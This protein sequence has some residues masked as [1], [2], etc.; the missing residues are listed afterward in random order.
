MIETQAEAAVM[1]RT[2]A[3]FEQVND[4]LQGTLRTL[5]SELSVLS[6]SWRGQGAMAFERVKAD[7]AADLR[8]LGMALTET[9]EA[10]RAA[11]AG[12]QAADAGAAARLTRAGQ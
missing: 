10:I 2:A 9:A 8:N 11:S 6:G 12:Y 7:Y 5:M 1:L 3:R 4:A